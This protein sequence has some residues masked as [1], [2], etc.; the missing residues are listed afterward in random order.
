M[1]R[2]T[3]N[4]RGLDGIPGDVTAVRPRDVADAVALARR[5]KPLSTSGCDGA[6]TVWW[7]PTERAWYCDFQR[8]RTRVNRRVTQEIGDVHAW[9]DEWWPQIGDR[10]KLA[11]GGMA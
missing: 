8:Y 11:P 4:L 3:L 9:L 2:S 5:H 10:N 6:L 1:K 7:H